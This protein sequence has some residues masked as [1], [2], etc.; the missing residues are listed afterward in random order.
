MPIPGDLGWAYRDISNEA[1]ESA[2]FVYVEYMCLF[3]LMATLSQ[4]QDYIPHR[5]S[6]Q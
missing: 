1:L 5:G 4:S 3:K 6:H 2:V